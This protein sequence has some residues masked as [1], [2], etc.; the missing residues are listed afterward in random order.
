MNVSREKR[1]STHGCENQPRPNQRTCREHHRIY[2]RAWRKKQ[3][4]LFLA[5]RAIVEGVRA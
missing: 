5:Y 3:R 4:A 2:M 1:C